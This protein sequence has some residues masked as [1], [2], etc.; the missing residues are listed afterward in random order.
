MRAEIEPGLIYVLL[1]ALKTPHV[2]L[3]VGMLGIGALFVAY[4][5]AVGKKK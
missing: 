2:A 3:L 5:Y 1:D 4:A